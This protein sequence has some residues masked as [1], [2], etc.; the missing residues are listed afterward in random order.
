MRRNSVV[1]T[2]IVFCTTGL[3]T[4]GGLRVPPAHGDAANATT[5]QSISGAPYPGFFVQGT[6]LSQHAALSSDGRWVAFESDADEF[7]AND[8]N[9]A[10]DVFVRDNLTGTVRRVSAKRADGQEP[11]DASFGPAITS[12]GRRVA[13][14]SLADGIVASDTNISGDAYVWDSAT[15]TFFRASS[16]N[17][18]PGGNGNDDGFDYVTQTTI[19]PDGATVVFTTDNGM[20]AV[21]QN[22]DYD[23]YLRDLSGTTPVR[24]SGSNVGAQAGGGGFD[25]S[26]SAFGCHIAYA[27][28]AADITQS[29]TNGLTDIFVYDRCSH[30]SP[31]RVR[32]SGPAAGGGANGRSETPKISVSGRYVA[33]LSYATNLVAAN[34]NIDGSHAQ[35]YVRDRDSDGN[36]VFDEAGKVTTTLASVA[37]GN[38]ASG[39]VS[40]PAISPDGCVVAFHTTAANFPG[41]AGSTFGDLYTVDRCHSNALH[42]VTIG[43]DGASDPNGPSGGPVFSPD[44]DLIGFDAAAT[45]LFTGDT[46]ANFDVFTHHWRVDTH[47][48]DLAN[49]TLAIASTSVWVLSTASGNYRAEWAGWD[50]SGISTTT[51]QL[52]KYT[53]NRAGLA[54]PWANFWTNTASTTGTFTGSVAGTTYCLR[55]SA[56][57]DG[58]AN[59]TTGAATQ[60]CRARPLLASAYTRT[61]TW[62]TTTGAG[63]YGGTAIR[64][65][66]AGAVATRTGIVG[67]RI[68]LIATLCPTCGTV[69]VRWNGALVRRVSLT[70]STTKR[71]T[72]VVIGNWPTS[73]TGTLSVTVVGSGKPVVLEGLGVYQDR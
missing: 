18:G 39:Q 13:F 2:V 40:D 14:T 36:G 57:T 28:D 56:E 24:L 3:G 70:A 52:A 47:G 49:T 16:T 35:L 41:G 45:N 37:S 43:S 51:V 61:G 72:N 53:W 21:D 69:D 9:L 26:T 15:N 5:I 19:S 59:T 23:V 55:L 46:N 48:P 32:V 8:A 1:A 30:P 11:D 66:T 31:T 62:T 50:P 22:G 42:R 60:V 25:P 4:L 58:A 6:D 34:A 65:V 63:I 38:A 10:T 12:D 73:H 64:S 33:F 68:D 44:G 67:R 29:D 54:T 71:A 27:S 20:T 7:V 17:Y